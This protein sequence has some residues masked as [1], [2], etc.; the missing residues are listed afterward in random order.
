MLDALWFEPAILTTMDITTDGFG[1]MLAFGDLAWCGPLLRL[2]CRVLAEQHECTRRHC[3]ER[4]EHGRQ[5]AATRCPRPRPLP[6]PQ[7]SLHLLAAGAGAGGP[8]TGACAWGE[9]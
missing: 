1:F 9:R 4:A 3:C 5:L 8:P 2:L 6:L 7:G